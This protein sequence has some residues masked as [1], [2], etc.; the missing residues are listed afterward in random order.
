[1]GAIYP[2]PFQT[3]LGAHTA[4][5]TMGTGSFPVVKYGRG[6]TL[7]PQTLLVPWSRK[8][9][10]IIL[11]PSRPYDLY[12][13]S[14]HV[15]ACTLA[16]YPSLLFTFLPDSLIYLFTQFSDLPFYPSLLFNNSPVSP[17]YLYT[18]LSYLSFYQTLLL[19]F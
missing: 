7:T 5:C 15:Q 18:R 14:V 6:L 10:A 8:G 1:V 9:R 16:F 4:S 17:I 3:G 13:A 11:F 19:T 2:A 12:R